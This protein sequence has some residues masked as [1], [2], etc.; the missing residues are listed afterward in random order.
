MQRREVPGGV[1]FLTFSCQRRLPLFSNAK[2]ARVFVRSLVRVRRETGLE[3]FAW[4]VMPEHVHLLVRPPFPPT[5][6][7]QMNTNEP[8]A[9]I[10]KGIKMAVSKRVLA[11][12]A[13]MDAGI[14]RKLDDGHGH[15]RFWQKGGGFDRNVR[16]R[17]E[18]C[19]EVRY[20]HRN[21]VERDLVECARD[22]EFSSVRWWMGQIDGEV[23]C[24]PPPGVPG[25]PD[26]WR[27]W[28]GFV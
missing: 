3:L 14:L 26:H 1:R 5:S 24:D 10:L 28:R 27:E 4:V 2:V 21:P 25:D 18:F 20:I 13:D 23:A 16:D 7:N 6:A 15:P 19:R 11:R 17:A 8:L 12:W 9:P 22:W